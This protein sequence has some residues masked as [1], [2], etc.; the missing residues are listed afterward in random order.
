MQSTTKPF[1]IFDWIKNIID[2]KQDWEKFTPEQQK[3][4]NPFMIN[5]FLSMNPKYIDIVNYVQGLNIQ[6]K[7][8][9]YEIYCWMIPQSKNTYSPYIKSKNSSKPEILIPV[10]EY[11]ECSTKEAEEYIQ[12]MDN[13]W[14]GNILEVKGIDE[15]T[16]KKLLK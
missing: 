16:I 2:I 10:A 6:E 5:K 1:S 9:I 3:L 12:L 8:K 13:K 7:Q 14:V 4:F 11:F 15:K